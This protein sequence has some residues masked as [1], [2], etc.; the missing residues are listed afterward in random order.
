M[1]EVQYVQ[2]SLNICVESH[3]YIKEKN[4]IPLGKLNCLLI[5]QHCYLLRKGVGGGEGGVYSSPARE[6]EP[7]LSETDFVF[8]CA[9]LLFISSE[10]ELC[11]Y[12]GVPRPEG[13]YS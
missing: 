11:L 4:Y 13:Y 10:C 7:C 6:P 12:F 8:P 5:C 9:L 1:V 3:P 2:L